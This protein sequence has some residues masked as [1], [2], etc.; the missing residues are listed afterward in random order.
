M[1][2]D[3]T[4]L[5]YGELPYECRIVSFFDTLGW[6]NQIQEAGT[7]PRYIARLASVPRMFAATVLEFSKSVPG[8][9][10][11]AFS[12]NVIVSVPYSPDRLQW[13]L[14]GLSKLQLGLAFAGFWVRGATTVGDLVHDDSVVF[15]PALNRAYELYQRR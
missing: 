3:E 4:E 7:D 11:T 14:E 9:Q 10:L 2:M 12:D 13:S 5:Q 6:R 15:G 1:L 8:A